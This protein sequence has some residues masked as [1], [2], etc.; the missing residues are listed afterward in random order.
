G[1]YQYTLEAGVTYVSANS[2]D[3]RAGRSTGQLLVVNSRKSPFGRGWGLLGL[4]EIVPNDDGS[5]LLIDGDG[6][7]SLFDRPPPD[8]GTSGIQPVT[9]VQ[10]LGGGGASGEA[11]P[12]GGSTGGGPAGSGGIPF[13][14]PP[15]DTSHLKRRDDNRFERT[16]E[17]GTTYLFNL[18][19]KLESETDRY[20]NTT[21]YIYNSDGNLNC[22]VDP[23]ALVTK[24]IYS[25]SRVSQIIRPDGCATRLFYDSNGNL[26]DIFDPDDSHRHWIYDDH[27]LMTR[28]INKLGATE[29]NFYDFAGR[30]QSAIHADGST[31]SITPLQ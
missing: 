30:A 10:A 16:L 27:G 2:I 31:E 17:D 25:G 22:I 28:E 26:T 24:F 5:A 21:R 7:E 20:G 29:R 15:G 13:Q 1:V 23:V 11:A 14:S 18:Q 3:A 12:C 19:N 9:P 4:Q 8:T 6:T